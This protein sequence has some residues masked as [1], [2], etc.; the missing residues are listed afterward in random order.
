MSPRHLSSPVSTAQTGCTP[1]A[2]QCAAALQLPNST[3]PINT[4]HAILLPADNS[5]GRL[6]HGGV[7]RQ[8][9]TQCFPRAMALH[10]GLHL[11]H[12]VGS[13]LHESL[14]MQS[15]SLLGAMLL[16]H[17]GP[18]WLPKRPGFGSCI[19]VLHLGSS[20]QCSAVTA[21][22]KALQG[23]CRLLSPPS[24]SGDLVCSELS[25]TRRSIQCCA[26]SAQ[27]GCDFCPPLICSGK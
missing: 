3:E 17:A 21:G 18:K 12:A 7:C 19:L 6:L 14:C 27:S 24:H 15:C 25:S 8:G 22:E 13:A 5:W 20:C 9:S 16:I 23:L 10:N 1:P 26:S 2:V 11:T 4:S